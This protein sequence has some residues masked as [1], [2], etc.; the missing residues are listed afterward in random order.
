MTDY[1]TNSEQNTLQAYTCYVNKYSEGTTCFVT[2]ATRK[3]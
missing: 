1:S 2:N 3:S